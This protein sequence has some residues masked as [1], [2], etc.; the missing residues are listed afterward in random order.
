MG[1]IFAGHSLGGAVGSFMGGYLFDLHA[2]YDWV[3]IVSVA[4]AALA[5]LLS[6]MIVEK[7]PG[8]AAPAPAAGRLL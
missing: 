3:W 2:R 6:V 7:R 4:L 1:L 8:E 5:G